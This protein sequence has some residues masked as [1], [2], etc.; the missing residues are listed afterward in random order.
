M[1]G[2]ASTLGHSRSLWNRKM[3]MLYIGWM[4][5]VAFFP[6]SVISMARTSIPNPD[7]A[8][9]V[10]DFVPYYPIALPSWATFAYDFYIREFNDPLYAKDPPFF[11]LFLVLE[12]I[13]LVPM[14]I[15]GIR[16]LIK[17]TPL[18]PVHLLVYSTYIFT[19]TFV[20]LWEVICTEDWPQETINKNIPGYVSFLFIAAIMWVDMFGRL[21]TTLVAKAKLS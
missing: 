15:M 6:I 10:L 11:Q 7:S 14:S 9:I 21:G 5:S 4:S 16:V 20:C 13:Y 18:A 3:D 12:C 17:D 1:A 19:T 8:G 2:T